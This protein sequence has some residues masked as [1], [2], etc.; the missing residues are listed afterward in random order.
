ME[1]R[2][3]LK[4]PAIVAGMVLTVMLLTLVSL[5]ASGAHAAPAPSHRLTPH[6][7]RMVAMANAKKS[8]S[9]CNS[10]SNV[11]PNTCKVTILPNGTVSFTIIGKNLYDSDTYAIYTDTLDNKCSAG[12]TTVPTDGSTFLPNVGTLYIN[13]TAGVSYTNACNPGKFYILLQDTTTYPYK[14]YVISP[15]LVMAH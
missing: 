15:T 4:K 3:S 14:T 12:G 10:S 7:A 8:S 6:E 13:V 9:S 11:K 5:S 2:L 1:R